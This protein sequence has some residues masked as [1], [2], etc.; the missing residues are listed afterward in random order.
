MRCFRLFLFLLI[1]ILVLGLSLSSPGFASTS[2]NEKEE[3]LSLSEAIE[4]A[5]ENNKELRQAWLEVEGAK[6]TRKEVWENYNVF[7]RQTY[8]PGADLYVSVPTGEDPQGL[9]YVSNFNWVVEE[10]NYLAKVDSVVAEVYKRYYDI[11]QGAE[12]VKAKEVAL[13][14]AETELYNAE[15]RWRLGMETATALQGMRTE[16]AAARAALE[17]ARSELD[18]HYA[19][20]AELLGLPG[21][22]RPSLTDKPAYEPLVLEDPEVVIEEIAENSPAVWIAQEAVRLERYTYGMLHNYDVDKAEL[23]AAKASVDVA[24]EEMR[25]LT[26]SL[27]SS[28]TALQESYTSALEALRLAEESLRVARLFYELG[29]STRADLLAAEA[30]CHEAKINL[31]SL[32]CQHELLKIAFYKPWIAGAVLGTVSSGDQ[33]AAAVP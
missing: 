3:P 16:V 28:I 6:E 25:Q 1:I 24:R 20:F 10:R 14:K 8:I 15:L 21:G 27:Y 33:T 32:Q 23:K 17:Q 9:V 2:D 12:N 18:L 13:C 11:L 4:L 31:L 5:L 19:E 22:E 7:L 26:R 30:A 29:M